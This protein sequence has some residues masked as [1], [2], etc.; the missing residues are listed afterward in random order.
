[1][2]ASS[3]GDY[4]VRL[5][6]TRDEHDD[7]RRAQAMLG[8]AVPNG[9][10]AVAYARAMKHYVAHLEKQ[11]FGVKPGAAV[12]APGARRI[13]KALRRFIWERDGGRCAFVSADGHR[14]EETCRL[15]V[16]HITPVALGGTSKPENLRLLCSAHN[17]HEAERVLDKE[18]VHRRREIAQ[19]E[20]ARNRAAAQASAERQR[21]R[22]TAATEADIGRA[23]AR[24]AARQE[25]YDD[26]YAG[27]RGLGADPAGARRG[28]EVAAA[29][30]D[31]ATL[32]ECMKA[33]LT[34]HARPLL[35]RCQRI[36]R[37]TT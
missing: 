1:V 2:T 27:L 25:R 22:N 31:E 35:M 8:H 24:D 34:A 21:A 19:R 15:E 32:E 5:T 11:R 28:A 29:M 33:A 36:P 23:K 26:V 9:D 13:P 30:P 14:C 6:I 37:C 12:D 10:P 17:Q 16:D 3:T 18:H 7:L 4:D 20:R